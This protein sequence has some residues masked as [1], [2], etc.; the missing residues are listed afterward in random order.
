MFVQ[1]WHFAGWPVGFSE[2]LVQLESEPR[3][4]SPLATFVE[5][6]LKCGQ[7]LICAR[8]SFPVISN[9]NVI[10]CKLGKVHPLFILVHPFLESVCKKTHN[11]IVMSQRARSPH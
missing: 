2:V 5:S 10:V 9:N 3:F 7:V 6:G 11:L 8:V 4:R 1:W